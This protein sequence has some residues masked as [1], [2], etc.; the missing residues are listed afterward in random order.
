VTKSCTS[1]YLERNARRQS[2]ALRNFLVEGIDFV[3]KR[4]KNAMKANIKFIER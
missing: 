3:E 2:P 1:P 4:V